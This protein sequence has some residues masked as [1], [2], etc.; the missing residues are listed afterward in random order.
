MKEL[1]ASEQ[2]YTIK[3]SPKNWSIGVEISEL[4]TGGTLITINPYAMSIATAW[5]V[6][7]PVIKGIVRATAV[8]NVIF[9]DKTRKVLDFT[10]GL[11]EYNNELSILLDGLDN[12]ETE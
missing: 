12:Q 1:L 9:E 11:G 6:E 2:S 4:L 10:S 5:S 3:N 7:W 8:I